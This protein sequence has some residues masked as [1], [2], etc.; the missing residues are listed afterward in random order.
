LLA[1]SLKG[2]RLNCGVRASVAVK[3][4]VAPVAPVFCVGAWRLALR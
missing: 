4:G 1:R 2:A 3:R